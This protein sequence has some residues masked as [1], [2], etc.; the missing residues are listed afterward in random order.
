ME[1]SGIQM[2]GLAEAAARL[3]SEGKTCVF[4]AEG[5]QVIGLL[6]LSDVPKASAAD[7]LKVLK[8]MGLKVAMITGD[9]IQTA[10]AVGAT[11]GIDQVFAEVLPE[12][13]QKR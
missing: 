10:R 2:N 11:L 13:N 1:A 7:A 3:A 12:I 5:D 6:G 4:V 8:N 9:N